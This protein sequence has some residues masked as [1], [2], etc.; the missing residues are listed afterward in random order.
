MLRETFDIKVLIKE[1][2]KKSLILGLSSRLSIAVMLSYLGCRH[3][4]V[5]LLQRLSHGTRAFIWNADGLKAF[6]P[7]TNVFPILRPVLL[8][9]QK[10]HQ[11]AV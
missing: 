10:L 9:S 7:D 4:I 8:N 6:I 2:K 11:P 5:P 3:E 1:S